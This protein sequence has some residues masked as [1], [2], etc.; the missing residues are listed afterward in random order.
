MQPWQPGSVYCSSTNENTYRAST[1]QHDSCS[2]KKLCLTTRCNNPLWS[3]MLNE[4]MIAQHKEIVY[5]SIHPFSLTFT[6]H[7]VTGSLESIPGESRHKV[8]DN[9]EMV[10]TNHRALHTLTDNLEMPVSQQ[11]M[12]LDWL[13]KPVS[14]DE[15]PETQREHATSLPTGRLWE[16]NPQTR[17]CKCATIIT[18]P[19]TPL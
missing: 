12:L 5:P 4:H 11:C 15:T 18:P 13:R 17:R 16:L 8:Q 1:R 9:L 2:K 7:M 6:L 14:L 10:P 3:W 19:N